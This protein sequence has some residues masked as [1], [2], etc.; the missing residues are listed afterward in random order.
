MSFGNNRSRAG[1]RRGFGLHFATTPFI[2]IAAALL[3]G[4]PRAALAQGHG[5]GIAKTC[6]SPR[7][8]G[9]VTICRI[10]VSYNDGFGDTL[11]ITDVFDIVNPEVPGGETTI[12]FGSGGVRIETAEGNTTAETG[13]TLPV[14]IGPPGS[15]AFGLP[16]DDER[17]VV[18]FIQD[19]YVI[20]ESDG[21]LVQDQAN[22]S[23]IDL[24]DAPGTIG[25]S[26]IANIVQFTAASIVIHPDI[27]IQKSASRDSVCPEGTDVTYNYQVTNIGDVDLC[28]LVQGPQDPCEGFELEVIDDTAPCMVPDPVLVNGFNMGDLDQDG[29]LNDAEEFD[30]DNGNGTWD[31]GE[32]W[33]D[34]NDND[35]R[36]PAETWFYQCTSPDVDATVI[37]TGTATGVAI[38]AGEAIEGCIA[39]DDDMAAVTVLPPPPCEI[40]GPTSVCE[41]TTHSYTAPPGLVYSW[42]T[43]DNCG[44]IQGASNLQSVSI[45]FPNDGLCTVLLT[46]MD[47]NDPACEAMCVLPV[48][49]NPPPPCVINGL[50]DEVCEGGQLTFSGPA[51]MTSFLWGTIGGCG[52]IIGPNDLQ[53]VTI[54]FP[55]V[56]SC[57]VQLYVTDTNGCSSG[58][59]ERVVTVNDNPIANPNNDAICEGGTGEICADASGGSGSYLYSWTG[60]G[61]FT[62][63]LPCIMVS[64]AGDYCVV[65]T[66][67]NTD[68][69][70]VEE[71]GTLTVNP[72]PPCSITPPLGSI[73]EGGQGIFSGPA[74]ADTYD[75]STTC[76]TIIGPD[77]QQNVTIMFGDAGNCTINLTTTIADTKCT[78]TC[79]LPVEVN[80]IPEADPNDVT[81]CEGDSGEICANAIG[82]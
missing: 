40:G 74:G 37:N 79:S 66:D 76:G 43:L 16:G 36:D 72:N 33:V 44:V 46:V 62:S 31:P 32:D 52:T 2:L 50:I 82:G 51:D 59:C 45:N 64:V 17:G 21:S 8:V 27:L 25:C 13:G 14:L 68:C 41:G 29:L 65:V 80:E 71:C 54:M 73:C 60:P 1:Q 42:S 75:W 11:S 7:K 9:D 26:S 63:D 78:S 67:A 5:V 77:D 57:T 47:F 28:G 30:D 22:V 18:T 61:G 10:Q 35:I 69:V 70:S 53:M 38:F 6:E 81:V 4:A 12:P 15:T 3:L 19:V 48:T 39:T 49:V 34:E 20:V 58:P 23:V 56:G 55:T 24:C